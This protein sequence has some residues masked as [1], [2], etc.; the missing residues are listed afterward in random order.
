MS[1]SKESREFI[2]DLRLY[3]ISSGKNEKEIEEIAG[4]LEDHLYEAEKDGKDINDI[5]GKTP[6]EYME[7]LA[8]EMSFDFKGLLKFIPVTILGA[9]SYI[10][11][12]DALRGEMEYSLLDLIGYPFIFLFTL[13]LSATSFKYVASN[14]ISKTKEWLIFWIVGS[15]PT[16]LFLAFIYWNENYDPVTYQVGTVGNVIAIVLSILIFIGISI[17]NKSWVFIIIPAILFL[18]QVLIEQTSLEENTK[19]ILTGIFI[20]V[21]IMVYSLIV[22]RREK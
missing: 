19:V 14:E 8:N 10:L 1:I 18:P 11:M 4:E 12:G 13:F 22:I 9:I 17:W 21:C 20:P 6:R 5:I 16:V 3:L 15:T 2:E 7:Q